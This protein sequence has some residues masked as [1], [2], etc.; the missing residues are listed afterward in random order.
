MSRILQFTLVGIVL[1]CVLA[2]AQTPD[3][4]NFSKDGLSFDY[5]A[6][7]QVLDDSNSDLQQITLSKADSDVKIGVFVH[8]GRT[9]PE[10]MADAK[11]ALVD[12]LIAGNAKQFTAMGAK[13]EQVPDSTE[14]AGLKAEG[15]SVN[16]SFGG[17]DTGAAKIYW[18]L[19]GQRFVM[20]SLFGPD[21][22]I[23]QRAAVW[24]LVRTSL[25][26]VDPKAAVPAASP[27]ASP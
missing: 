3:S 9:S 5:P 22:E 17:G 12:P 10:K 16:A 25:K 23:K 11:K 27:K 26:V 2:T 14:I 13:T 15:T 1:C 18:A 8:R 20:L 6:S 19:V 21:K 4:K 7:W 24:D